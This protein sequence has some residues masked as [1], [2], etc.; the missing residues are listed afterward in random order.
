M[1]SQGGWA[2][3]R[4]RPEADQS[5]RPGHPRGRHRV[6]P[7]VVLRPVRRVVHEAGFGG[8]SSVTRRMAQLRI[9]RRLL[10]IIAV[11]IVAARVFGNMSMPTFPIG[12][13][14]LV[15]GLATL[16]TDPVAAWVHVQT[17]AALVTV[18]LKWG[19][20]VLFIARD[21]RDRWRVMNFKAS[22][23]KIAWDPTAMPARSA[24]AGAHRT[25]CSDVPGTGCCTDLPTGDPAGGGVPAVRPGT[26][27]R[28]AR[29]TCKTKGPDGSPS[30]PFACVFNVLGVTE[31]LDDLDDDRPDGLVGELCLRLSR[32]RGTTAR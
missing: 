28:L 31:K 13:N 30:G 19:G 16:G 20:W 23:E 3:A 26:P 8:S 25:R 32:P 29:C 12:P 9:P 6:P 24:T 11:G 7:A 2:H 17:E 22:G 21:R 27:A 4:L 5:Q 10:F 14:V 1:T 15:A 18:G